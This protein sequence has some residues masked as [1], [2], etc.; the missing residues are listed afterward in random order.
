[1]N[2]WSTT[3]YKSL[4]TPVANDEY[5][6]QTKVPAMALE[7][8]FLL[9]GVFAITA[10]EIATSSER[11]RELYVHAGID[12]QSWAVA[13]FR[14]KLQDIHPDSFEAM[15]SFSLILMVL[16]LASA[17][18]SS[19]MDDSVSTNMVQSTLTHFELLRGCAVVLDNQPTFIEESPYIR[20]LKRFSE[21]PQVPLDAAAD[22]AMSKL[23]EAN[24]QRVASSIADPYE[25]RVEQVSYWQACKMAISLLRECWA[26]CADADHRGYALGWLNMAGED[27]VKAIKASDGIALLTLMYWGVLVES[28][29]HEVWWAK[30]FGSLLVQEISTRMFNDHVQ[31]L[32]NELILAARKLTQETSAT[33]A[34]T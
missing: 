10:F 2:R 6:W 13:S 31:A 4:V 22:A 32:A 34:T 8:D 16:A 19:G 24:E 1:M 18:Y 23:S 12:Y 20:R 28:L 3:T 33:R 27:Y 15:L 14:N 9:K 29:G 11:E 26:K 17:R 25:R 5:V 30:D 7:H 21:L